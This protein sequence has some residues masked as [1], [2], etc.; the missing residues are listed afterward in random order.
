[1]SDNKNVSRQLEIPV[2]YLDFDEFLDTIDD[3]HVVVTQRRLSNDDLVAS[4]QPST[5]LI[6]HDGLARGLGIIQ[7]TQADAGRLYEKLARRLELRDLASISRDKL[8]YG[9]GDDAP[10]SPMHRVVLARHADARAALGQAWV[11]QE[12][13]R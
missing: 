6:P 8:A 10:A 1:M 2:T 3:D 4:P 12:S 5:A 9:A 13:E 7:V 11:H